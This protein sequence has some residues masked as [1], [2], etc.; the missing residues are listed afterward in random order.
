MKRVL[1][2][3]SGGLKS[4]FLL[5]LATREGEVVSLFVDSGHATTRQEFVAAKSLANYYKI[6]LITKSM[7]PPLLWTTPLMNLLALLCI[8]IP[9]AREEKCHTIYYGFDMDCWVR[10]PELA[11]YELME[12][13]YTNLR[14]LVLSIQPMYDGKGGYLGKVDVELPLYRLREQHVVRLGIDYGIQW[15][16]TWSC[17]RPGVVHCGVCLKCLQRKRAFKIEG[18]VKDITTY[19]R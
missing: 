16:L 11:S 1:V 17:L 8:A 7:H 10:V 18:H 14:S 9:V 15:V 3:S 13:F 4:A 2:L 19:E 6:K 5:G 12:H